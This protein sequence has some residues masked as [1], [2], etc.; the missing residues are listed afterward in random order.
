[1]AE[2]IYRPRV[3]VLDVVEDLLAVVVVLAE[4]V[5]DVGGGHQVD[6][7]EGP[8][9]RPL[10]NI[11]APLFSDGLLPA[12]FKQSMTKRQQSVLKSGLNSEKKV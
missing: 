9:Q 6:G 1:M 12:I 10:G 2:S 11:H 5:H 4:P 8:P 7:A 3:P